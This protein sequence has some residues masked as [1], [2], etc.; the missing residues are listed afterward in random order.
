M[1]NNSL[2][3]VGGKPKLAMRPDLPLSAEATAASSWR[4]TRSPLLFL[5]AKLILYIL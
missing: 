1:V 2:M 5:F 4:E 3:R